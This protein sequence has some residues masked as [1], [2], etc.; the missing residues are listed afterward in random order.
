MVQG[1]IKQNIKNNSQNDIELVFYISLVVI[2]TGCT[3][4]GEEIF[5]GDWKLHGRGSESDE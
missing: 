2:L 4:K 3:S 1:I 5:Y